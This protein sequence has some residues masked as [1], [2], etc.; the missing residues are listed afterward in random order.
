MLIP[1]SGGVSVI[2]WD[3]G[4]VNTKVA[5]V[6][7]GRVSAACSRPFE[8]Q[9]QPSALAGLLRSLAEAIGAPGDA[10]HAVTMTAELSQA[11]RTKREGVAF[12][13]DAVDE[14]FAGR[15]VGVLTTAGAFLDTRSARAQPLAVAAANWAATARIVARDHPDALLV[16]MGTTTTDIIPIAAG[17]VA[18]LGATDPERLASGELVYTGAV[19][20]PAEL[21]AVTV[22]FGPGFARLSAEGF[23]LSGDVHVWRGGLDAADYHVTP[24]GRPSSAEY[25]GERLA[26]LVCA[27]REM[28]DDDAID[29]VAGALADGQAA[30]IVVAIEQ[31]RRRHPAT[32]TAVVT[33]LGAFIAARAA[34]DA[35][36]DV[37]HLSSELGEAASRSAPAAAVA[38]L[39]AGQ[40]WA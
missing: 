4:G 15:R 21:M 38:L 17:R 34:G 1:V 26:R 8:I 35:G 10:A 30:A 9:R 37:V 14:A 36:L 27:D 31:V 23:A 7:D 22:P 2:G 29:A 3:I 12:V 6:D 5:R 19:R 16:D 39:F 24:D 33:G 13:L 20:T 32:R 40:S 28:L 25:A 18:S 11:F